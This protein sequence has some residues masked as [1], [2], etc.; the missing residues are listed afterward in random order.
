MWLGSREASK[1]WRMKQDEMKISTLEEIDLL[2]IDPSPGSVSQVFEDR[3]GNLW[4]GT[5]NKLFTRGSDSPHI[6]KTPFE[7]SNITDVAEDENG[8]IWISNKQN[9][10]QLSYDGH[11]KI[12]KNTLKNLLSSM[13]NP[14]IVYALMKTI[15]YGFPLHWDASSH[16]TQR[17]NR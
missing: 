3:N 11:P 15:R 17:H 7:I 6:S 16:T 10:Y 1:V 14:L 5:E 13:T 12:V 8:Y 4:I 2:K 9:I